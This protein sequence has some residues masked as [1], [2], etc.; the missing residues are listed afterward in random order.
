[1]MYSQ[2]DV[3]KAF[4]IAV[5]AMLFAPVGGEL[6]FGRAADG[7]LVAAQISGAAIMGLSLW[8]TSGS[9]AKPDTERLR[10]SDST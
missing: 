2:T 6:L 5:L 8:W 9:A 7:A 10:D 4:V 1:M 3:I